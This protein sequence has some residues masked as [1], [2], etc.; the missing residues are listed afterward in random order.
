MVNRRGA[1]GVKK[2]ILEV[3][4]DLTLSGAKLGSNSLILFFHFRWRGINKGKRTPSRFTV[5]WL[6]VCISYKTKNHMEN[7]AFL[8]FLCVYVPGSS[9]MF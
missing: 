5:V 1:W 2:Q 9:K 7:S 4:G 3:A 6:I 8:A